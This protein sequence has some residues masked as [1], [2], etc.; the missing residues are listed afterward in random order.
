MKNRCSDCKNVKLLNEL[1]EG[2]WCNHI[3]NGDVEC[4][5]YAT[6][7]TDCQ[8]FI[9]ESWAIPSDVNCDDCLVTETC[10]MKEERDNPL[11]RI[12]CANVMRDKN[13]DI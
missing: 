2:N 8:Y 12:F 11:C 6:T 13:A 10:A 5:D 1:R 7:G 9:P 4:K 3:L